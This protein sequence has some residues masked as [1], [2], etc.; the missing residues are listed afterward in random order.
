[1]PAAQPGTAGQP[2]LLVTKYL[3]YNALG[4]TTEVTE[5]PGGGTSNVRK[6]VTTYDAAGRPKTSSQTGDG[7]PIPPTET[8]YN[9]ATGRP[10]VQRFQQICE[11]TCVPKDTRL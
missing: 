2:Q 5:S 10:E 9:S 6:T 1:M 8:L 4:Q 3:A 7:T 11:N